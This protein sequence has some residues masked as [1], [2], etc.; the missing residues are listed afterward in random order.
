M[1]SCAFS[2]TRC[3]R[4]CCTVLLRRGVGGQGVMN[5]LSLKIL[6]RRRKDCP[7]CSQ[8][9]FFETPVSGSL[10][11]QRILLPLLFLG[12]LSTL[13]Y[14]RPSFGLG[15]RRPTYL[16]S[17][18]GRKRGTKHGGHNSVRRRI[19]D[20]WHT[21]SVTGYQWSEVGV[22]LVQSH[23]GVRSRLLWL[24]ASPIHQP[25]SIVSGVCLFRPKLWSEHTR[26]LDTETGG[27]S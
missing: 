23:V 11:R 12:G 6:A 21:T 4:R 15:G 16:S 25:G 14:K 1:R 8:V 17:G 9:G 7:S 2:R 27:V 5:G 26:V 19:H 24:R 22:F 13:P 3:S 20:V 18:D 10:T